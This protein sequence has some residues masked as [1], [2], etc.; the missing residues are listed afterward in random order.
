MI[1]SDVIRKAQR[2]FGDSN[3]ILISQADFFDF[4]DDAQLRITREVGN[5]FATNTAAANTYPLTLPA[6]FL[7]GQRVE[8]GG[9]PLSLITVEDLEARSIDETLIISTPE[10]YYYDQN[11]VNLYPIPQTTD[12]TSVVFTYFK[13]PT[14]I[15]TTGQSLEVPTSFHEDVVTWVVM[16][17][18]ERNENWN[19][20]QIMQQEF[21]NSVG[22]R[23]EEA[24]VKDDSYPII[25]D[26]YWDDDL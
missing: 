23:M 12:T 10:F 24:K 5:I 20:V 19:A 25:R 2:R 14:V 15:T 18:H 16:R 9:N 7:Q 8:Y 4:I 3:N 6:T 11:K 1:V 17:S 21:A 22:N 13:T 26:D